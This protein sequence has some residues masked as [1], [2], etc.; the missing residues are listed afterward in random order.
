M[1]LSKDGRDPD[2]TVVLALLVV[3][4]PA[5]VTLIGYWFKQQAERRLA[6]EREQAQ[7]QLAQEHEESQRRLAQEHEESQRRLDQEQAQENDRLRLDA[8]MRAADLFSPSGDAMGNAARSAS[9]L[10]ALTRLD[11][12]E[13]AV[14]L[15]VDLWHPQVDQVPSAEELALDS[16]NVSTET[17]IQVINAALETCESDAQLMAAELLCR[18]SSA[19]DINNS[20]HWPSSVNSAWIPALPVTAKLLI[21]DALVHMALASS[22]TGNSLRELAVR[23]YGISKGDPE[24]RVKGCVGT[25]MKAIMPAVRQLD[26]KDFMKGPGH[27]FVTL[28]EMEESADKASRHPDGYF[29]AIVEDRSEK[30]KKWSQ[31]CAGLSFSAGMLAPASCAVRAA[32]DEGNGSTWLHELSTPEQ[33]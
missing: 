19:L 6:Q 13:L 18:N 5:S 20:L 4:V 33:R 22:E 21:V 24:L 25:L 7:E 2:M 28:D 17:A 12:A 26:Y 8:A 27:G 30:L 3:L 31:A 32:E 14:A 16:S 9:G 11:F 15:L 23:L 10:L 29:E 1:A